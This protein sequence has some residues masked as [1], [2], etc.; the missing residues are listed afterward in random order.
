MSRISIRDFDQDKAPPLS[1]I[2]NILENAMDTI[3]IDNN[4]CK[5][6]WTVYVL[7]GK[8]KSIFVQKIQ[9]KLNKGYIPGEQEYNVYP[10]KLKLEYHKRRR[11][12]A[13]DMYKLLDIAYKDKLKRFNHLK[14][15]WSFFDAP[16]GLIFTVTKM[17]DLDDFLQQMFYL[18]MYIQN[19]MLL[20]IKNGIDNCSQEAWANF[21]K[22]IKNELL[23]E[24]IPNPKENQLV[25]CGMSIGYKNKAAP[26]NTLRTE[27]MDIN[28]LLTIKSKI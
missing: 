28:K 15:N 19:V 16:I 4:I 18:G 24:Y 26:V 3:D 23:N 8:T 5:I 2:I 27:R 21:S 13:V 22:T 17:D 20:L 1:L 14:K 10:P 12:V 11:K 9:N 6:N 7:E 25:F